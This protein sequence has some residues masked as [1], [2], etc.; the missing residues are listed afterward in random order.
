MSTSN[1]AT[2]RERRMDR[3][4][5]VH[6]P[7]EIRG[8]DDAGNPFLET[9]QS[10]NVSRGGVAFML[11]RN[12]D[13]GANI[14]IRIPIPRAAAGKDAEEF[15]TVGRVVHVKNIEGAIDL[16][17]GVEFTGRSFQRIFVSESAKD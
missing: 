16:L 4:V 1:A 8:T 15:S 3:R 7:M 10:V 12:F 13:R 11:N 5:A 2:Q 6:L 9:T 14:E 17:I